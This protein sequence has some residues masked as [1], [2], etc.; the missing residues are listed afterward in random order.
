MKGVSHFV[1]GVAAATF[2]PRVVTLAAQG[3]FVLLL[4]GV[5]GVLPDTLDFR[6]A[7]Y[8]QQPDV[9]ISPDP[10]ARD[11]PRTA[12]QIAKWV[13]EQTVEAIE[14]TGAS[15]LQVLWIGI[16]PQV[17]PFIYGTAVYRWDIN[18]CESSVLGFVGAGGVGILLYVDYF[19]LEI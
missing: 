4:A 14:A 13:G 16:L 5:G 2:I 12:E 1:S 7:R 8:L 3:S 18:I 6:L 11:G 10:D 19:R 9:E 17:L 15:R